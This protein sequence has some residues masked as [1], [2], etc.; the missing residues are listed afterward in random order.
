MTLNFQTEKWRS[1]ELCLV[2]MNQQS[3]IVL[4]YVVLHSIIYTLEIPEVE[5]TIVTS[6]QEVRVGCEILNSF[7]VL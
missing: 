1:L 2:C 5:A 6:K 4:F 3:S 7:T